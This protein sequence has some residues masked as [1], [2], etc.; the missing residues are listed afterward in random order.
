VEVPGNSESENAS[1]IPPTPRSS[2]VVSSRNCSTASIIRRRCSA[3][4][5]SQAKEEGM[6]PWCTGGGTTGAPRQSWSRLRAVFAPTNVSKDE[7]TLQT[8]DASAITGPC[9]RNR[10]LQR[11]GGMG[12]ARTNDN[13]R[14]DRS[15]TLVGRDLYA[16]HYR[17]V[18]VG[19]PLP[20]EV[21]CSLR[22]TSLVP[23]A[24]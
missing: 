20:T 9:N 10:L 19:S 5:A 12:I 21:P 14:S 4:T 11:S 7:C 3:S 13:P 22:S 17:G 6:C 8:S 2:T 18:P 16:R 1:R 24:G 23:H 15:A